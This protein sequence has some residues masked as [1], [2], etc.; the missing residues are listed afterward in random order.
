MNKKI[1]RQTKDKRNKVKNMFDK[2]SG[3]YDFLNHLL[4]GG[5]D[6]Y[7]R[8]F[9]LKKSSFTKQSILLD[10]A[11]GTGDFSKAAT[12]FG[13]TNIT[14]VDLS[15]E[16]LKLYN[17]KNISPSATCLQCEA[18][19]L[20]FKDNTFT[21]IS[22][23]FGVRNFHNIEKGF[24]NFYRVLK[25]NGQVTILEFSL[26]KNKFIKFIYLFYFKNILPIIG[27]II[28]RDKNAYE[29]LPDSVMEFDRHINLPEMLTN[30]G[31]KKVKL[32]NLTFG[33][34]QIVI[35]NKEI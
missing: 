14:G 1:I 29:Y 10:V 20:P 11:C 25:N 8:N 12:K 33:L 23:A 3:K 26:P 17:K 13:V 2:I 30:L 4:S 24:Q 34:V 15:K 32:I 31:F 5:M 27:K 28:S 19:L 21:N 18:E 35:A 7:W 9:A 6:F 22:V 16:M